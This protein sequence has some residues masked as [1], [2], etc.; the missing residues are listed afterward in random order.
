MDG[1]FSSFHTDQK[2]QVGFGFI[3]LTWVS[4]PHLA[5]RCL[6]AP[7]PGESPLKSEYRL[8]GMSEE[9]DGDACECSIARR[10]PVSLNNFIHRGGFSQRSSL[11]GDG[12]GSCHPLFP[13]LT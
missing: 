8:L 5:A 1:G 4:G 12:P 10:C 3:S 7:S 13:A 2:P 9:K 6:V 11:G